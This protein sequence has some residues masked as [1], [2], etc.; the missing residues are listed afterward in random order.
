MATA[1]KKPFVCPT[2]EEMSVEPYFQKA[3]AEAREASRKYWAPNSPADKRYP[4]L[5]TRGFSAARRTTRSD[6]IKF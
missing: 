2:L 1:E 4:I 6:S 3:A 5:P